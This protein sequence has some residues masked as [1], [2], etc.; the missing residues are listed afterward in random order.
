MFLFFPFSANILPFVRS[1]V[2]G[3]DEEG[4]HDSAVQ[5]GESISCLN[6]VSDNRAYRIH[7]K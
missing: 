4:G 2:L 1:R 7:G 5:R 6:G 3:E